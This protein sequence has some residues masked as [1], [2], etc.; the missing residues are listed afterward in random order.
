MKV[1]KFVTSGPPQNRKHDSK[2]PLHVRRKIMSQPLCKELRQ[3]HNVCSV[4]NLKDDEVQV[5]REH[6]E[7][8]QVEKVVQVYRK[9]YV[10]YIERV[11]RDKVNGMAIHVGIHSS[12]VVI[13]GL[14]LDRDQKNV[15]ERKAKSRQIG[16]EKGKHKK[17]PIE[18]TQERV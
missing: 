11:Q 13:T 2:A 5:V 1:H 6:Y 12:K 16:K 10:I 15:L 7:S 14:K 8:Q 18:K 4:R 9:K 17:E 3:K